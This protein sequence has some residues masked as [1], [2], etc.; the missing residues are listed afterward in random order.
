MTTSS[1]R[2]EAFDVCEYMTTD[3]ERRPILAGMFFGEIR[4]SDRP[5]TFPA[6]NF[7]LVVAPNKKQF[8]FVASYELS[9]TEF[10]TKFVVKIDGQDE[11]TPANRLIM[12]WATPE[13]P[14]EKIG[15]YKLVIRE[16]GSIVFERP[17]PLV[18]GPV[19]PFTPVVSASIEM[20]GVS[21]MRSFPA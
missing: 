13:M 9:E 7:N 21:G 2:V 18:F 4:F 15:E 3:A 10:I 11:P 6:M 16:E 8:S 17:L 14:L 5:R 20:G 19:T 12:G 1:F